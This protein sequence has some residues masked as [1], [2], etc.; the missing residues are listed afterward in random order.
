MIYA[1]CELV[2]DAETVEEYAGLVEARQAFRE[3]CRGAFRLNTSSIV[4]MWLFESREDAEAARQ[5]DDVEIIVDEARAFKVLEF[6]RA[7]GK[8]GFYERGPER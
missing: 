3:L 1:L 6:E 8:D 2:D 5:N 4:G 7:F